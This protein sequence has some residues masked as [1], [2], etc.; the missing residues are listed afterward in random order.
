M[1]FQ[2]F[3]IIV[4]K[5]N[6]FPCTTTQIKIFDDLE[7]KVV[8]KVKYTLRHFKEY[9]KDK[10]MSFDEYGIYGIS[11]NDYNKTVEDEEQQTAMNT[12]HI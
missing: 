10:D 12:W 8:Y 7:I 2:I 4:A 9:S 6:Y 5:L 1:I 3:E 11:C